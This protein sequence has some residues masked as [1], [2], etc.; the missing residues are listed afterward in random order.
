MSELLPLGQVKIG[1]V[2]L[3]DL[4]H[5][6]LF[7]TLRNNLVHE[8]R[9]PG[10]HIKL[11]E[12]QQ[13]HYCSMSRIQRDEFTGKMNM[14]HQTWELIHPISFYNLI[15]DNAAVRLPFY[16]MKNSIDPIAKYHFGSCWL[17]NT[18]LE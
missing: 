9:I 10:Y 16:F 5:V 2:K 15:I 11:F 8:M 7:W 4:T 12:E 18:I 1:K 3:E 14:E 6:N 17:E 13:P